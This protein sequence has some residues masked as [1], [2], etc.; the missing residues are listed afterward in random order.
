MRFDLSGC[1]AGLD[2]S[3]K[4][5]LE[6]GPLAE[7]PRVRRPVDQRGTFRPG[8]PDLSVTHPAG[9]RVGDADAHNPHRFLRSG[10]APL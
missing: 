6:L 9:D 3:A 4:S 1:G 5:L 8:K 2:E 7:I 10:A